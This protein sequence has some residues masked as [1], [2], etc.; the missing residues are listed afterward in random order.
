MKII[1]T[2]TNKTLK[3]NK[4]LTAYGTLIDFL[5]HGNYSYS[6][7]FGVSELCKTLTGDAVTPFNTVGEMVAQIPEILTCGEE[8]L[9]LCVYSD[10]IDYFIFP[11]SY[12]DDV[13]TCNKVLQKYL[14]WL[15]IVE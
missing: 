2:V 3:N 6:E 12:E 10:T 14:P 8:V 4:D 7:F 11:W 9:I 5:E 15:Q 13:K 1:D